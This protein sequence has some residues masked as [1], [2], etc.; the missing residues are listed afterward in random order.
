MGGP[1]PKDH[2]VRVH[3]RSP[4][5]IMLPLPLP[6]RPPSAPMTRVDR[7]GIVLDPSTRS[8]PGFAVS[9]DGGVDPWALAP[10][11]GTAPTVADGWSDG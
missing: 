4:Y 1:V 10:S 7:Y 2:V 11:H 6:G 9:G 5:D 8:V 3:K